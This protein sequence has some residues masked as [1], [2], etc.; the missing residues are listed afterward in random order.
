M[1]SAPQP[2][3]IRSLQHYADE[4]RTRVSRQLRVVLLALLAGCI[5]MTPISY[6][7]ANPQGFWTALFGLVVGGTALF[8]NSRDRVD[9]AVFMLLISMLIAVTASMTVGEGIHD[10]GMILYPMVMVVGSLLLRPRTYH[11]IVGFVLASVT[12]VWW[13]GWKGWIAPGFRAITDFDDIIAIV[14]VLLVQAVAAGMLS[15]GLYRNLGEA[16]RENVERRAPKKKSGASIS[17]S[18]SGSRRAL[19]NSRPPTR[20]SK[21]FPTRSPTTSGRRCGPPAT[22]RASSTRSTR[23][24]GRLLH[25]SF[26]RASSC[27]IRR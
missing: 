5:V 6:W 22:M 8:L 3:G 4:D 12:L 1:S 13:L 19:P 10:S 15:G 16:R 26:W 24:T 7:A 20:N 23:P 21:L 14:T 17:S 9:A 18:R 2:T 11:V 25:D 27:R